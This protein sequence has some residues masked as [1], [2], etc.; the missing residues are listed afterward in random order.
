MMKITTPVDLHIHTNASDGFVEPIEVLTRLKNAGIMTFSVT[1]HDSVAALDALNRRS[2]LYQ[3]RLINGVELSAEYQH[4]DVH[5][6]GYFINHHNKR[7]LDYLYLFRRRR[8]QRAQE[9]V[10]KLGKLGVKISM[11]YVESLARNKPIG[12][13]HIADALVNAGAVG[14]RDEAFEK[15]LRDDGPVYLEKYRIS[16]KEVIDLIHS[17]GGGAFLAHPGLSL[18]SDE[19]V[20]TLVEMGLDGIEVIHPRHTPEQVKHYTSLA[21]KL[22][23]KISGGSDFHGDPRGDDVLGKYIID[24]ATL[25]EIEHYCDENR[26]RWLAEHILDE[27][28]GEEIIEDDLDDTAEEPDEEDETVV[29]A[30][31]IVG[32]DDLDDDEVEKLDDDEEDDF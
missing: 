1:D 10:A 31:K 22:K 21:S 6:L 20:K 13:P 2:S 25:S 14:S 8:H 29:E 9:M 17:I 5:F 7:F 27:A 12:R 26:E 15:Y 28:E 3:M 32:E 4:Q 11:N 23:M 19:P 16:A 18:S 30:K 24:I